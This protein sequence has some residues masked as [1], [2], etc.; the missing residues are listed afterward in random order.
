MGF[1]S[2]LFSEPEAEAV[3]VDDRVLKCLICGHD[4]FNMREA[5]LNTSGMSQFGL[6]FLNTSGACAVCDNCGFIHWFLLLGSSK[7]K[8]GDTIL[9]ID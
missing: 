5:Q 7:T 2:G 6:D 3:E 9:R 1:F 4:R 8:F